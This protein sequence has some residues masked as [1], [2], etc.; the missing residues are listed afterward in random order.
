MGARLLRCTVRV[1][2]VRP[3][4]RAVARRR[5][6]R[7]GGAHRGRPGLCARLRPSARITG[8]SVSVGHVVHATSERASISIVC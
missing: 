1:G 5:A 7:P 6:A 3:A 4:A 2:R 8:R